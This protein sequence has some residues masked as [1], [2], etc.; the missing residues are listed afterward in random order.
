MHNKA[1]VTTRI[2][3]FTWYNHCAHSDYLNFAIFLIRQVLKGVHVL[4]LA[5]PMNHNA[6]RLTP[7]WSFATAEARWWTTCAPLSIWCLGLNVE[8]LWF[9]ASPVFPV[10]Q[11][12]RG[13]DAFASFP[14]EL[15]LHMLRASVA[16][17][18]NMTQFIALCV[19][20]SCGFYCDGEGVNGFVIVDKKAYRV[21]TDW[22]LL[23]CS[24]LSLRLDDHRPGFWWILHLDVL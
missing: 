8:H 13:L 5:S 12:V 7:L 19:L 15:V 22:L 23:P 3:F 14:A 21:C 24:L 1:Q 20:G 6:F 10:A 16:G 9:P 11:D 2:W 4:L 17:T 18:F